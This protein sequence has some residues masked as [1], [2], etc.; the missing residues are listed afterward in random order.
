MVSDERLLDV[1]VLAGLAGHDGRQRV[2]VIG[3][4]DDDRVDVLAVEHAAEV[5]RRQLG[6]LLEVLVDALARVF[7]ICSSSTSQSATHCAPSAQRVAQIAAAHAAAADQADAD[8]PVGAGDAVLRRGGEARA[9]AAD[10]AA[11]PATPAADCWRNCRRCVRAMS[12]LLNRGQT[13]RSV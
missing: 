2:P 9:G 7:V 5:A 11:A 13:P 8:A 3:R 1:D 12:C 4:A 6:R 10:A